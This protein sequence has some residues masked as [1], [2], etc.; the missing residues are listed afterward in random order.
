MTSHVQLIFLYHPI[1]DLRSS[2][3]P[4]AI[5]KRI[6]SLFQTD[7]CAIQIAHIRYGS[8]PST[9]RSTKSEHQVD[10][11]CYLSS[12]SSLSLTPFMSSSAHWQKQ[13]LS[14]EGDIFPSILLNVK[15]IKQPRVNTFEDSLDSL[16]AVDGTS[17]IVKEHP[18]HLGCLADGLVAAIEVSK[19]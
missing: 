13:G 3:L 8:L 10:M 2:P 14:S 12:S 7:S 1:A 18:I 16:M 6:E 9:A 17:E 4:D 15:N 19:G 11:E 5:I